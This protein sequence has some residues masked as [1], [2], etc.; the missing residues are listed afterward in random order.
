MSEETATVS[1]GFT[2]LKLALRDIVYFFGIMLTIGMSFGWHQSKI[3][4]LS[5][6]LD[7]VKADYKEYR[8]RQNARL[9][10]IEDNTELIKISLAELK[11]EL[12]I[13]NDKT[14]QIHRQQ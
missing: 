13:R 12:N 8:E 4:E 10:K 6:E 7:A 14:G 2:P 9:E 1:T 3:S 11:V 5:D